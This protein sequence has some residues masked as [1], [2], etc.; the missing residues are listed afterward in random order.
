M[1]LIPCMSFQLAW[2][3]MIELFGCWLPQMEYERWPT[4]S[5]ALDFHLL[6]DDHVLI[7]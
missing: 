1:K 7:S 4:H 5:A 6:D 3:V 2:F